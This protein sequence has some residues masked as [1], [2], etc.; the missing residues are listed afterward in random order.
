MTAETAR[1]ITAEAVVEAVLGLHPDCWHLACTGPA[2]DWKAKRP[3]ERHGNAGR[4]HR[5]HVA[6]LAVAALRTA[7]LA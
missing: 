3:I 2:C 4:Q 7:G 6:G 1:A 5:R